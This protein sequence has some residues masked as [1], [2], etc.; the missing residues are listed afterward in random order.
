M[1]EQMKSQYLR[2]N[3]REREEFRNFVNQDS[4]FGRVPESEDEDALRADR[5]IA[6]FLQ[7]MS[8]KTCSSTGL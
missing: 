6:L 1:L 4:V 5:C 3:T 8:W 7:K 2:L